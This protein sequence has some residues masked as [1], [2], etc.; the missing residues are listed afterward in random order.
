MFRLIVSVLG[1]IYLT[2]AS[3]MLMPFDD[4]FSK[5]ASRYSIDK[6]LLLAIARTESN[7]NPNAIGPK[8]ENGSYDIGLMQINSGW[9]N[10]LKS[11]GIGESDLFNACTNIE[12]GT[13]ILAQNIEAH[14]ATW[15]AVGA[16]NA[17]SIAKRSVYVGK[18][19]NNYQY[20]KSIK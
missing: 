7:F 6:D 17:K 16:Y 13:W 8:N 1:M 5:S 3:A 10:T 15:M 19:F 11:Y 12:V 20:V 9:I 14:G 4:C 18:V 2:S